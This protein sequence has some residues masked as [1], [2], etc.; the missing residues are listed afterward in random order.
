MA[1]TKKDNYE[2]AKGRFENRLLACSAG[3]CGRVGPVGDLRQ[4]APPRPA[5][6]G[7][8]RKEQYDAAAMSV[9][10]LHPQKASKPATYSIL[11]LKHMCFLSA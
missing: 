10:L 4:T 7:W 2:L 3:C 8:H 6:D 5:E 9:C 11:S 1:G